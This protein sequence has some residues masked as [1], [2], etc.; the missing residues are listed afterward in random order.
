MNHYPVNHKSDSSVQIQRCLPIRALSM[1]PFYAPLLR[2]SRFQLIAPLQSLQS[3]PPFCVQPFHRLER[4]LGRRVGRRSRRVDLSAERERSSD[5]S[6]KPPP[7][8]VSFTSHPAA[9]IANQR[10]RPP[11][12]CKVSTIPKTRGE[13]TSIDLW[14]YI[15]YNNLVSG[16]HC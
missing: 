1:F 9:A 15:V 14:R 12:L 16:G 6:N 3:P 4:R 2:S 8:T 7:T 11:D 10:P 5:A 13:M